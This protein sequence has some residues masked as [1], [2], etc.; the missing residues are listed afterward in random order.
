MG[1]QEEYAEAKEKIGKG[2]AVWVEATKTV[3]LPPRFLTW[4][5]A[6][7]PKLCRVHNA[8]THIIARYLVTRKLPN[9]ARVELATDGEIREKQADILG[10]G[11]KILRELPEPY[12][13]RLTAVL[14]SIS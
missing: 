9:D 13:S 3:F 1:Y 2:E 11:H 7:D 12:R 4:L 5:G 6:D 10:A 8:G 14:L